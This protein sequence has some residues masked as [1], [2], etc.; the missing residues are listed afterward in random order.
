LHN[1]WDKNDLKDAQVILH[2]LRTG[3]AK[4]YQDPLAHEINDIQELSMT[5]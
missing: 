1:D 5:Q 2:M 4:P 3:M